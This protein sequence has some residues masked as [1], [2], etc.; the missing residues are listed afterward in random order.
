[1]KRTGKLIL[2]IIFL[3]I[4]WNLLALPRDTKSQG[5]GN[6]NFENGTVN[7]EIKVFFE[8]LK[9]FWLNKDSSE[10]VELLS[11]GPVLLTLG[12]NRLRK[13][14]L[15]KDQA[16]YILENHFRKIKP[17]KFM[18][19]KIRNPDKTQDLRYLIV[20]NE[21]NDTENKSH[22]IKIYISLKKQRDGLKIT[23]I[24]SLK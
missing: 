22:R 10:I 5:S 20:L 12:N 17:Q 6:A 8:T 21:F 3:G 14:V 23:E 15:S 9:R 2:I 19:V 11:D 4:Q 18:L 13:K 16:F 24:K 1:M 7:Q